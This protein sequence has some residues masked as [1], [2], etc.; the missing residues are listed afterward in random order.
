MLSFFLFFAIFTFPIMKGDD[1]SWQIELKLYVTFK[2]LT[3]T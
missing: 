1:L 3:A 2:G